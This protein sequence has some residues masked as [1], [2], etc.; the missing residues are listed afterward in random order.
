MRGGVRHPEAAPQGEGGLFASLGQGKAPGPRRAPRQR[1]EPETD[2]L[3]VAKTTLTTTPPLT[4]ARDPFAALDPPIDTGNK[5]P[6][7]ASIQRRPQPPPPSGGL[8]AGLGDRAPRGRRARNA[9]APSQEPE[10][11]L[12]EAGPDSIDVLVAE[13]GLRQERVASAPVKPCAVTPVGGTAVAEVLPALP[14]EGPGPD[15]IDV[16]RQAQTH[17]A[18]AQSKRPS[19]TPAAVSALQPELEP[20]RQSQTDAAPAQ[21]KR[22]S[23]PV[24]P[25][26]KPSQSSQSSVEAPVAKAPEPKPEPGPRAEEKYVSSLVQT[27]AGEMYVE[28][29]FWRLRTDGVGRPS[30][31]QEARFKKA[32]E[33]QVV[34]EKHRRQEVSDE[35]RRGVAGHSGKANIGTVGGRRAEQP[36]TA[37]RTQ[38]DHS[39]ETY[40]RD[41]DAQREA[42]KQ[43]GKGQKDR[44][45][46]EPPLS[47]YG[48]QLDT[49]NCGA[50]GIK[51]GGVIV[52][53]PLPPPCGR[54]THIDNSVA[55]YR[56]DLDEQRTAH[57]LQP[58]KDSLT[59]S[60]TKSTIAQPGARQGVV[61][62]LARPGARVQRAL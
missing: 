61:S 4:R 39:R 53:K 12:P 8:F 33:E 37:R 13:Q 21:S 32:L 60:P 24:A 62:T 42:N 45:P 15:S 2:V 51:G 35:R 20:L 31:E 46:T 30:V 25:A 44:R 10:R 40:I 14:A 9:V 26:H 48:D 55:R 7:P 1:A 50:S 6:P 54:R 5:P 17:A 29:T 41:L 49:S 27:E 16:M 3:G 18:P 47:L 22:P 19:N 58:R 59:Q 11:T 56:R 38:F 28:D 52:A 36:S 57:Q 34:A 43:L 23:T